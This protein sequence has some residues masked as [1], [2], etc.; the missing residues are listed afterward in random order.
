MTV[1]A[2]ADAV[3]VPV[4]AASIQIPAIATLFPAM[5]LITIA[6]SFAHPNSAYPKMFVAPPIPIARHPDVA[7]TWQGNDFITKRWRANSY[8]Y[9]DQR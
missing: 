3:A 2:I 1:I 6:A 5:R 7:A 8:R 9:P 4:P